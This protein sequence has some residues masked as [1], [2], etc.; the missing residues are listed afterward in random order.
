MPSPTPHPPQVIFNGEQLYQ[1]MVERCG[2]SVNS[3]PK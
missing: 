1:I 2:K 3:L